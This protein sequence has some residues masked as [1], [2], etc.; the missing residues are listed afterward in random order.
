MTRFARWAAMTGLVLAVSGCGDLAAEPSAG[1]E[2]AVSD[3]GAAGPPA[4]QCSAAGLDAGV[5]PGEMVRKGLFHTSIVVRNTGVDTC[6]IDGTSDL[7]LR[8][9]KDGRD[10][11]TLEVAAEGQVPGLVALAPGGKAEMG[12]WYHTTTVDPAA[13]NC[14]VDAAFAL[15]TLPGHDQPLAAWFPDMATGFPPVCGAIEI[16]PWAH[17][18]TAGAFRR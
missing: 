1:T 4:G 5:A 14:V 9:G 15:F 7:S 11:G 10:L 17:G 18:G 13:R 6:T 16:S 3:A 2:T 8:S 12:L